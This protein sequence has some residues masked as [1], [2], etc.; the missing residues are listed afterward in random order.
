MKNVSCEYD[1]WAVE[2][3]LCKLRDT[4]DTLIG[5]ACAVPFVVLDIE[6]G[7]IIDRALFHRSWSCFLSI[8]QARAD[9][10]SDELEILKDCAYRGSSARH[11]SRLAAR[12]SYQYKEG[13]TK[14]KQTLKNSWAAFS[15]S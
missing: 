12:S 6:R 5:R 4:S 14:S 15:C 11:L 13:K 10:I 9:P 8:L 2:T 3:Q 7:M 1:R